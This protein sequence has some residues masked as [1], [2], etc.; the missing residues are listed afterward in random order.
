MS[1]LLPDELLRT[2]IERGKAYVAVPTETPGLDLFAREILSLRTRV[3]DAE[4]RLGEIAALR[5]RC[6][7]SDEA[8]CAR[9]IATGTPPGR[10]YLEC[11][12]CGYVGKRGDENG[13]FTDGDALDCGC[14]GWVSCDSESEPY[15]NNGDE[16]CLKCDPTPP[17]PPQETEEPTN[18]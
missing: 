3:A 8:G 6:M 17:E 13:L 9:C 7:M 12:C 11:S 10:A 4:R 14:P 5:C 1:D 15:I 18:G 2:I 16:P